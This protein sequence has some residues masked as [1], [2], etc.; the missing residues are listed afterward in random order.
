MAAAGKTTPR[1]RGLRALSEQQLAELIGRLLAVGVAVAAFVVL[2]GGIV[3]LASSA[4]EAVDYS[5]LQQ[6]PA[7]L[8]HV[9]RIVGEAVKFRGPALIQ[10]GILLLI[11]T[12]VA[13]VAFAALAFLRQRDRLYV[14]A[15][16]TVLA[17]LL[18]GL[19]GHV[20]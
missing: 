9:D 11:A 18:F 3:D 12:P 17:F 7:G 16:L 15:T 5:R 14:T 4:R 13:R 6:V 2:L 10:L 1:S 19:F 8:R 20:F